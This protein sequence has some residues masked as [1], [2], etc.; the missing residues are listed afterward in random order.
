[1]STGARLP[2]SDTFHRSRHRVLGGGGARGHHWATRCRRP[3][4]VL[5]FLSTAQE[6]HHDPRR[7]SSE[8]HVKYGWCSSCISFS[9]VVTAVFRDLGEETI[10]SLHMCLPSPLSRPS[11]RGW[12]V[13]HVSGS[14][15]ATG[16]G[17]GTYCSLHRKFGKIQF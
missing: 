7:R 1:M 11:G 16:K 17:L 14:Y 5:L 6:S 8:T 12:I 10:F 13:A 9:Y 3:R 2:A 4:T 15:I